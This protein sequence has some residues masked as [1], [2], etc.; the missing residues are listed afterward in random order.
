MGRIV[1][2]LTNRCNLRCRHCIEGRHGGRGE[3]SLSS[4][5]RLLREAKNLGFKELVFSG[6]EPTLH[7][8][9]FHM[10]AL[11]AGA[12]YAF[13]FVTNGW[14]FPRIYGRL[15][16]FRDQLTAVTFSLDGA[17]AATHDALRGKDSFRRVLQSASVCVAAGLP[18]TFDMVVTRDNRE[19]IGSLIELGASVGANGVRFGTLMPGSDPTLYLT[20]EERRATHAAIQA[21]R[22]K[23]PIPI[24]LSPGYDTKELLPCSPLNLEEINLDWRANVTK[25]SRLS[26]Y[27]EHGP[28]VAGNLQRDTLSTALERLRIANEGFIRDKRVLHGGGGLRGSEHA[29]CVYCCKYF[30]KIDSEAHTG[31]RDAGREFPANVIHFPGVLG[32][33]NA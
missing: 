30:N 20:L 29:P 18:F 23:A 12:G 33:S 32:E 31:R 25:C 28:D 11:S 9:F 26:G 5:V 4:F 6:G 27:T 10:I 3:L 15:L 2:E 17:T 24:T 22:E 1:V 19:H 14:T 7:R 13:G 8:A 16:P 21:L